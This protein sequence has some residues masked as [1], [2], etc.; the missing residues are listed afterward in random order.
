MQKR[1]L[2]FII[3]LPVCV[4][5]QILTPKQEEV[6]RSLL[7]K[8]FNDTLNITFLNA[9][10]NAFAPLNGD[11]LFNVPGFHYLFKLVGD[12]MQ[13][14]DH[15]YFHG[16]N[17]ERY[18]YTHQDHIYLIG[19][20]GFFTTN[21]HIEIFNP[22]LKE[23]EVIPTTGNKPPFIKGLC[24]KADSFIYSFYNLRNGNMVEPDLYDPAIYRLNLHNNKWDKFINVNPVFN[25]LDFK[26]Y[27]RNFIVGVSTNQAII[28]HKSLL[29]YI[30]IPREAI[31]L[32]YIN[33][34]MQ[35]V[36][37]GDSLSYITYHS[38][39]GVR[40]R[41]AISLQK[42]WQDNKA[43][44]RPFI[45]EPTFLQYV[46]YYQNIIIITAIVILGLVILLLLRRKRKVRNI[47][48]ATAPSLEIK[49]HPSFD[50]IVNSPTNNLNTDE[51]D[52]LLQISHMEAESRKLKRHRLLTEIEH[53]HPGLI[54][55]K[56]D[57]T[58]KRR[59]L[60]YIEK[61]PN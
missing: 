18:L 15:S 40:S 8:Y 27:S 12:T 36:V 9:G 61:R 19:G 11:T 38:N 42:I 3:F 59:Y 48:V 39:P 34:D 55:R 16:G 14:L 22:Q 28:I 2:F 49:K 37:N 1:L 53:M 29:Q 24:I 21:N 44:A 50:M 13:R 10:P 41:I 31:R 5:A 35:L 17:F 54:Q 25:K 56:K 58:D 43:N 46:L 20:Y 33:H 57:E 45:L 47:I 52:A 23:W 51:L 60:Y 7:R 26:L 6:A 32:S 30:I 4:F